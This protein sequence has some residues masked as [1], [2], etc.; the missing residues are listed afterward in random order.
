MYLSFSFSVVNTKVL[1]TRQG[2]HTEKMVCAR[3]NSAA[4]DPC[5]LFYCGDEAERLRDHQ[6]NYFHCPRQVPFS[7][8]QGQL[9]RH[10]YAQILDTDF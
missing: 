10:D 4:H 6:T 9:S 7:F 3:G 2:T 8:N 5:F 1:H